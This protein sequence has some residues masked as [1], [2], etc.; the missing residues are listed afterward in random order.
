[1]KQDRTISNLFKKLQKP[2]DDIVKNS[3]AAAKF[4]TD[5]QKKKVS[6]A[7]E[8]KP[9]FGRGSSMIFGNWANLA[10]KEE[11]GRTRR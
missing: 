1:M 11:S 10:E 9:Q 7:K 4:Y 3:D 2:I 6:K 8:E 5:L